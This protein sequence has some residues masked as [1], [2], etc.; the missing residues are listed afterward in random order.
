MFINVDNLPW[1]LRLGAVRDVNVTST[2][3]IKNLN[4]DRNLSIV[5][6]D[7]PFLR[8]AFKVYQITSPMQ[9]SSDSWLLL[10][11]PQNHVVLSSS[12]LTPPGLGYALEASTNPARLQAP[13]DQLVTC[14]NVVQSFDTV[15]R[16]L[17]AVGP[18]VLPEQTDW[19]YG[20]HKEC[21]ASGG[22]YLWPLQC[23]Y[24]YQL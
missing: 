13:P 23:W 24:D 6:E 11:Q 3:T 19:V 12:E 10:A 14:W 2:F 4:I 8:W 9:D 18:V 5:F 7:P 22:C 16:L 1:M 15:P 20:Q 17:V 21:E